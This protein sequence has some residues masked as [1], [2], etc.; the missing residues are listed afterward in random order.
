MDYLYDKV[1]FYDTLKSI[2]QGNGKGK[3]LHQIQANHQD[4]EQHMLHFLENHD[5]QRIASDDFA[6][7][8]GGAQMGKPALVV[9]ALI[10][11]SPT[12]LYFGQEVGEDGSE[13]L[14]F[15]NP[16]RTSIFDYGGVPAHQRWMNNGKFDGGQLSASETAL[17]NFYVDVMKI[18][19]F[20]PAMLGDYIPLNFKADQISVP[21]IGEVIKPVIRTEIETGTGTESLDKLVAFVRYTENQRVLV[22][23]H[24]DQL[25]AI[26]LAILLTAA[27]LET[28]KLTSGGYLGVDLLTGTEHSLI[29]EKALGVMELSLEPM[30]SVVIQL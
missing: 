30:Q 20:H 14:G 17:R 2:M 8:V 18:S 1:E 12:L 24:F 11:R 6:G 4:I 22:V 9:S 27:Q 15:G 26:N 29:V 5:E 10:S 19:A 23:S 28:L 16:S 21:Q 3:T 13:D 25:R 7:K